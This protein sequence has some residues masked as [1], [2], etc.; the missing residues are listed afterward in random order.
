MDHSI[1]RNDGLIG[2]TVV[3]GLLF[4]VGI[5]IVIEDLLHFPQMFR[6]GNHIQ[7]G[8]AGFQNP[9]EFFQCQRGKTVQQD[10]DAFIGN[11]QVIG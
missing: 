5:G 1:H 6:R 7:E 9:Q 3:G 2:K 8:A 11:R 10:I 4:L